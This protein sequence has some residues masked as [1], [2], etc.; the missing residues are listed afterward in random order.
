MRRVSMTAAGAGLGLALL[1]WGVPVAIAGPPAVDL[2]ADANRDGRVDMTG[3]SDERGEDRAAVDSGA[4][5]LPN[6]D[7]D[8]RR[9]P[10]TGP[11]G[12]PLPE[13]TLAACRD[14]ADT[15]VNGPQDA[16]DLARLRTASMRSLPGGA[17]G[18]AVVTGPG[19][20]HTRLFVKRGDRWQLLRPTDKL[21]GADLGRGLEL[22]IEGTD[23]IRDTKVWDGQATV[24]L[25]VTADGR[26]TADTVAMRVA[27]V[28]THHHGQQAKQI[29]VSRISKEQAEVHRDPSL[30]GKSARFIADL[31]KIVTRAGLPAPFE[32]TESGYMFPQDFFEPMYTSMPG[33]GGRP[34]T[35][36]V[37]FR[38]HQIDNMTNPGRELY[39]RLR[40]PD[41]AVVELAPDDHQAGGGDT[42]DSTGNLE[43]IP[44][45]AHN[46]R[47]YPAGRVIMGK[48]QVPVNGPEPAGSATRTTAERGQ[49]P[50][51]Q[52]R[53]AKG[54]PDELVEP[55]PAVQTF[56]RSQ[57]LQDP[58]L[59][60]SSWTQVEHVDEFIQFLPA[61][62]PR[63][64][65]VAVADP[66]AGMKLLRDARAAGHG[67][68]VL[69]PGGE[70]LKTIDDFLDDEQQIL[71]RDN[72]K[73]AAKIAENL[74]VVKRETGVT[75]SEVV[76]VP[77][78]FGSADLQWGD[79]SDGGSGFV[80]PLAAFVRAAVN[81]VVL[82]P[83]HYLSTKQDGGPVV[84]GRDI[85]AEAVSAAYGR[86]GMKV[87]YI[88]GSMFHGGE[89][90]CGT[91]ML[92]DAAVPWWRPAR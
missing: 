18:T 19:A 59:L 73:A 60:D 41:T 43:T 80:S 82:G 50:P 89:V 3:K 26:T 55:S 69:A 5:F 81:G 84:G 23:M 72:A 35:M 74:E 92:R 10:Y 49:S 40:G 63:G 11:D 58:L 25:S 56:L 28:L 8:Q 68:L 15:V 78:L 22:G 51:Q 83:D 42:L 32:F 17:E 57:G 33:P 16:K 88:D 87:T 31:K 4:V 77:S 70:R 85:F 91:N 37:L 20:A 52:P 30:E 24:T 62:T 90:H 1:V 47:H 54:A 65:R 71:A 46:G 53:N 9:C 29:M 21:T 67:K 75:D 86:A 34:Q 36:R 48:G 45:Y 61:A 12:K 13:A 7:D 39:Q 38:S 66:Q 27:P 14:G 44:P 64:W 76:R 79:Q 2:R 6:L